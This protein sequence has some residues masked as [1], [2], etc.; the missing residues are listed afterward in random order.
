MA[1][2][3]ETDR[4]A[5]MLKRRARSVEC[6]AS[7]YDKASEDIKFVTVPGAQWDTALKTRRGDRPC[8]EFPKLNS[9]VRQVVNEMRQTRPQGKVRGAEEND[10]GLAEIMQGIC[11]NI[12]S[13]S[14][15]EQAYDIAFETAVQGGFGV[16]RICTDY[17]NEDDFD[18]D[19]RIKPVRNPFSVRFDPA[20]MDID[21]RD[22]RFAFVDDFMSED[23]AE[24]E[25][26][27]ADWGA[28]FDDA[29][30]V[31][32]R[33][34]GKVQ[35]SEY[36][37]KKPM[38]RELWALSSG[39]VVFAD[40]AGLSEEELQ[41]A[42]VT[43]ARR[44]MI[45]SHKVCM[46]LTNGHEFLDEPYEFPSKFIPLIPV[47]G[48]IQ[49]ID[50]E[51][52]WQGMVRPSKDQQR[53]HNVHRTAMTE[54][55]AKAP[56]APFILKM[57]WI[58]GLEHFWKKANSEDYPYL[59]VRD[60]ADDIP[61]RAEQAQVPAALIQLA[62][63]DN[64]D[65][66]ATT[67]QYDAS[68]GARSNETSGIA[69][70]ERKQSGAVA[71]FNYID[72]LMYA[73]RYTYEILVDM[74]P[75]V[76]DTPRVVRVL[77]EDGGEK[78]KQLYQ[79]VQDPETG[80]MVVL[81]DISKG[82]YDVVVTVGP[83]YA[84]QRLEAV[85]GFTNMLGQ[86]G[87]GLPPPIAALMAYTAVKNMDLPGAEEVDTAFRKQLVAQG[88]LPPKEGEDAPPQQP[89][90]DPRLE[91]QVKKLLADAEKSA[92]GA[93]KLGAEAQ[94]VLPQA[95]ADIQ[96]TIAEAVQQQLQNMMQSGQMAALAQQFA[97]PPPQPEFIEST[98]PPQGGFFTPDEYPP[99]SYPG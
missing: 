13:V 6:S 66:K 22:G 39:A 91:A 28:F 9:H 75:Q 46:Q 62:G 89:P 94:A 78:W 68:L 47:W 8:Y 18:L 65:M 93:A 95:Q 11:R 88:V 40:T 90:P 54:A 81:N 74:I 58:K 52:Y 99:N 36:W 76:Y 83:S 86:M 48:N 56:K 14:N 71:T 49:N 84:T 37:Y 26:P 30:C 33:E 23:E 98:Q 31:D 82:K 44:R 20:A 29:Q 41:A 2:A 63:M 92:A 1:D 70:R 60:D 12:E 85:E 10:R 24:R 43:I 72:N 38:R 27:E 19:I 80:E 55:V 7:L 50:G 17:A 21:R 16:W 34:A 96:K 87:N 32:W 4:I 79:E 67:G 69:Q 3:K 64:D 73:I 45:N 15:A 5:E 42:G 97:M 77:G 51:D 57:K 25:Y 53:L 35:I 61:K 59:P